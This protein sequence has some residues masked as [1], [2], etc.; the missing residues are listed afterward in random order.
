MAGTLVGHCRDS[1]NDTHHIP[2]SPHTHHSRTHARLSSTP[3]IALHSSSRHPTTS[4]PLHAHSQRRTSARPRFCCEC[5][6]ATTFYSDAYASPK[7]FPTAI[8][9]SYLAPPIQHP[10]LDDNAR[11]QFSDRVD[12]ESILPDISL[13]PEERQHL[14]ESRMCKLVQS[15]IYHP[16]IPTETFSGY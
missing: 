5:S 2:C 9:S 16:H 8:T 15:L 6:Q 13:E 1:G 10:N 7:P 14:F 4:T 11:L 3:C 12:L